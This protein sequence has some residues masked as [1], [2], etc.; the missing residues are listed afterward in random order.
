MDRGIS[1]LQVV[2]ELAASRLEEMKTEAYNRARNK[3]RKEQRNRSKWDSLTKIVSDVSRKYPICVENVQFPESSNPYFSFLLNDRST[4][5]RYGKFNIHFVTE[6]N[7]RVSLRYSD[8]D[9]YSRSRT[10]PLAE[11]N[12]VEELIPALISKLADV[13][14]SRR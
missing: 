3:I 1:A 5:G 2:E 9:E 4:Y 7:G 10:H 11:A 8:A 14:I 12:T 6:E 13:V